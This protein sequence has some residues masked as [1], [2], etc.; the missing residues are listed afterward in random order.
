MLIQHNLP[1]II[2]ASVA[3]VVTTTDLSSSTR[4]MKVYEKVYDAVNPSAFAERAFYYD[5]QGRLIQT[6]EQNLLGGISRTSFKY[7]LL[8][9]ILARHESHQ[10]SASSAADIKL[11]TCSYDTRGRLLSESTTVTSGGV[12][13]LA[14]TVSYSYDRLGVLQKKTY[15]NSVEDT[16]AYNIQGWLINRNALRL[17]TNI[18]DMTL[19]Y[20]TKAQSSTAL[21]FNGN[22][23]EW[24]WQHG[25][26]T[27][28]LYAFTYDRLNFLTGTG[29][30]SGTTADNSFTERDIT[31]NKNGDLTALKR[32]GATSSTVDHNF[33][34]TYAGNKLSQIKDGTTTYSYTH[35]ANGNMTTDGRRNIAIEY[36]LL[37]LPKTIKQGGVTRATYTYLAD[38][39]KASVTDYANTGFDYLGSLIYAHSSGIRTLESVAFSSG[40]IYR[41]GSTFDIEYYITD[42]LGSTRAIVNNTGTVIEQ[43]DYYLF[44]TRHYN[45]SLV[46]SPT[47]RFRF[48]GK[49]EQEKMMAGFNVLDFGARMYDP[50]I[51]RWGVA[52]PL[53]EKYYHLSPYN[54]VGNS[55]VR[56]VD[57]DGRDRRLSYDRKNQTITVHAT[58]YHN[59][60]AT[61]AAMAGVKV[62]ND[63]KGLTYTDNDGTTWNVNFQLSTK[64]VRN[65]ETAARQDIQGNTFIARKTVINSEGN[66]TGGRTLNQKVIEVGEKYLNT[67]VPVHEIGHTLGMDHSKSGLMV[68]SLD[69]PDISKSLMQENI[70]QVIERGTGPVE[71]AKTFWDRIKDSLNL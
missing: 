11:T 58:Y 48:S 36:N 30:W 15:G 19:R 24:E 28:S 23:S 68:P 46:I 40:R 33:T 50:E 10:S 35:D 49:E 3:N 38:G 57:I 32:Y 67:I 5:Y 52:D 2:F 65:P 16:F 43:N 13:S 1:T 25:A 6:V 66:E 62:F 69:H 64:G 21:R 12:T 26:A 20:Y 71:Q 61:Q 14:A 8:G 7:D 4:Q 31:Y 39:V 27:K 60:G 63:M 37:N 42:H 18:F 53:A 9:N 17:G 59:L 51:G 45:P 41:T 22:I 70:N 34:Y 29:R 44:G 47:N 56:F 55:P 54:Y